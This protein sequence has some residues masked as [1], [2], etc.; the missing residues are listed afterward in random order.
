M[1]PRRRRRAIPRPHPEESDDLFTLLLEQAVPSTPDA[2]FKEPWKDGRNAAWLGA[3]LIEAS[4]EDELAKVGSVEMRASDTVKPIQA[5]ISFV[6]DVVTRPRE[7]S[8][9]YWTAFD[10]KASARALSN[11][12]GILSAVLDMIQKW[13]AHSDGGGHVYNGTLQRICEKLLDDGSDL[14]RLEQL[15]RRYRGRDAIGLT[16]A[17]DIEPGDPTI[18]RRLHAFESAWLRGLFRVA[19]CV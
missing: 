18:K 12:A 1:A 8:T 11:H 9:A 14:E 6:E 17:D 5:I 7:L 16:P 13:L 10:L 19:Y 15:V 4:F 2:W 3:R